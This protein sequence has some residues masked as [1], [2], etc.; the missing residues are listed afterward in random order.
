V[1]PD[2]QVLA[3][4]AGEQHRLLEHDA[5]IAPERGEADV[6]DVLAVEPDRARLRIEGAVQQA[7]RRRLCPEP[8][9]P[10]S[11]TVSPGLTAKDTSA[12]AARLPS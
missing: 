7:E 6:A 10:T 11:A 9:A 1:A 5:D 3:D 2:L 4:R 12:T 8:V